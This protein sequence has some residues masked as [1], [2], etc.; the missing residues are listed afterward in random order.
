[1]SLLPPLGS[2]PTRRKHLSSVKLNVVVIKGVND[3][4]VLDFVRLAKDERVAIRFIEYMPFDDN[5]WA[6]AKL[7]PSADLLATVQAAHTDVTKLP[8]TLSDTATAYAGPDWKGN[9]GCAT[10]LTI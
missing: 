7:V 5:S 9:V 6:T 3:S 1:M 2:K 8:G 4:E 10:F